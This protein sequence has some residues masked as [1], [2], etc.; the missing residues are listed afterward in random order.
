MDITQDK[1]NQRPPRRG[2]FIV[3]QSIAR[4]MGIA[5]SLASLWLMTTNK[6]TTVVYGLTVDAKYSYSSAFKYF[7]AANAGA[8]LLSLLGLIC[9]FLPLQGRRKH[10]SVFLLDLLVM[11]GAVSGCSAAAAFGWVGKYGNTHTGWM[12]ICDKFSAFCNRSQNSVGIAV[13]AALLF[14]ISMIGSVI[15]LSKE[16]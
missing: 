6:Q 10:L 11:M 14:L 13:V 16:C 5:F 9:I 12:A 1:P 3:F 2:P 8:S 4:L 15:K 7:V